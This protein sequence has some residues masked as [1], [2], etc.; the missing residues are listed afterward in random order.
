MINELKAEKIKY[1]DLKWRY[2][3][4]ENNSKTQQEKM[5]DME[6]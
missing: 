3:H 6:K 1:K 4:L 2:S 5:V